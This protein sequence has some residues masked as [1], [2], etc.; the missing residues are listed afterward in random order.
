MTQ[1]A[2]THATASE[3]QVA[4][5]PDPSDEIV[6]DQAGRPLG[7]R[8]LRTRRRILKATV[9]LLAEKPMRNMRVIDIARRI[10]SSPATFYQYF[11]DAEDVVLHLAGQM[12]ES[13]PELVEL[14][15]GDWE[16]P[17]GHERGRKITNLVIDHWEKFAPVLRARNNASDE[18]NLPLREERMAAMLPLVD[19]FKGVIARS[20]ERAREGDEG[21]STEEWAGGRVDP[22]VGATALASCL[23]RLAMYNAWITDLGSSREEVVETTATFMQNLLTSR[24]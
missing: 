24:R 10:G 18:G 6:V 13:T 11:K 12:K 4:D 2:Q 3:F 22:L 21:D 1:P 8:A 17:A 16:G 9:A 5:V 7:P 14:I 19:A 20:I 23:E 15:L